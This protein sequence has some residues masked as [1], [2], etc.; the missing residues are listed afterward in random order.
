MH[1]AARIRRNSLFSFLSISSRLIVN[2]IV[3]WIIGSHYGPNVFG[4]FTTAHTIATI[5]ILFADFGFDILLTTEIAK[6]KK[7]AQS[8]FQNYFSLKVVFSF[9]ALISMWMLSLINNFSPTSR[10]LILIFSFYVVLTTLTNFLY[11]LYKG[12][13]KLH[14]ETGVSFIVN[15]SLLLVIIVFLFLKIRIEFIAGAFVFTRLVGFIV[16]IFTSYKVLPDIK[17][18]LT[19]KK[20]KE[21]KDQVLIFGLHLIF[22]NLF[23]QLDTLLLAFWKGDKDVGIYQAAFKLIAL[24]LVIP[25]ILINTLLPVLS[26]LNSENEALWIKIG[27][28]L[29]K[30]LTML[31][32]PISIILFIYSDFIISLIYPIKNYEPSILILRI[33]AIILFVRFFVESYALMLTTSHK[34]KIRMF[35]VLFGTILNFVLNYF[36]IPQFGPMGAAIISLITNLFVGVGYIIS[37]GSFISKW[38]LNFPFIISIIIGLV[39]STILWNMRTIQPFIII[40]ISTIVC[41][42]FLIRFGYSSEERNLIF[43]KG[44]TFS[45][46]LSQYKLKI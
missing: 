8:I 34:Q 24:P 41:L 10:M 17:F 6:N 43:R 33:F 40:P 46:I 28:L 32:I 16:A 19:F 1:E 21:I 2:V 37:T 3:F 11:A 44:N 20:W 25:D 13:E 30:T 18:S 31:V 36:A 4:Q 15:I 45:N 26:R 7:D 22:G 12:F 9:A 23:F 38:A 27:G 5:F 39:F 14:Y 35:I 29:N 42:L